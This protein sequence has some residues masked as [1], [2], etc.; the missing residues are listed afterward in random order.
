M[1]EDWFYSKLP[2]D[3]TEKVLLELPNPYFLVR[4][5]SA[6]HT[7]T[8]SFKM[9]DKV[10]HTRILHEYANTKFEV[11]S[12]QFNK[13]KEAVN[14]LAKKYKLTSIS[15]VPNSEKYKLPKF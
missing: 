6:G 8:F 15:Y 13:L 5:G 1:R 7:F 12:K 10:L 11:C 4:E 3:V 9:K 2:K 14:Y